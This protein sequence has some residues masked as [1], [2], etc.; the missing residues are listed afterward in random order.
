MTASV[1][2]LPALLGFAGRNED[3]F[4]K[5]FGIGLAAAVLI[6]ATLVRMVQV[7]ATV[8]LLGDRSWRLPGWHG[9]RLP[10]FH[11][12]GHEVIDDEP[13]DR[14]TGLSVPPVPAGTGADH[15]DSPSSGTVGRT[16]RSPEE[17]SAS[18]PPLRDPE[19]G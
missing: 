13:G 16:P 2:L 1:T 6:D 14:D 7:P 10:D 8:A 12:E 9:R 18:G 15:G 3:V 4:G 17:P 5:M 19:F 11:V